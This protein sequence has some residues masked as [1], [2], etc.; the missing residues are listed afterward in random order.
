MNKLR[1]YSRLLFPIGLGCLLVWALMV[2]VESVAANARQNTIDKIFN[3]NYNKVFRVENILNPAHHG[4]GFLVAGKSGKKY[5]MTNDH[6]CKN[7]PGLF[8][9]NDYYFFP[10][11]IVHQNGKADLCLLDSPDFDLSPIQITKKEPLTNDLIYSLGFP[12]QQNLIFSEGILSNITYER[13]VEPFTN[14]DYCNLKFNHNNKE[15][16]AVDRFFWASTMH[17]IPG[18]SGS[19][20][21]DKNGDLVAIVF[22]NMAGGFYSGFILL[23]EIEKVLEKF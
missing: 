15:Y 10:A 12:A 21:L 2:Y 20:V 5:I 16:C 8:V 6:V 22:V 9:R 19:P 14:Q 1:K 11:K 18:Q 7:K 23:Q 17:V 13:M 3:K 4:T